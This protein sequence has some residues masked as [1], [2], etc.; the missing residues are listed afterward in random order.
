MLTAVCVART[1]FVG[2]RLLSSSKEKP[3][4]T[5]VGELPAPKL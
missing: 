5:P 2:P 1:C 3:L 4:T